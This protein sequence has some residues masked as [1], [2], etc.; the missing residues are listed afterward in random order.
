MCSADLVTCSPQ[1]DIDQAVRMMREHALR[2]LPVIEDGRLVGTLTLG[3]LAIER[4]PQSALAD[5]GSAEPNLSVAIPQGVPPAAAVALRLRHVCRSRS[6]LS[7]DRGG[8]APGSPL[9]AGCTVRFPVRTYA[10][11][12]GA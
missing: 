6:P 1:D 10:G 9:P 5:I 2:R 8:P 4:D 11:T 12:G 3:G 7:A